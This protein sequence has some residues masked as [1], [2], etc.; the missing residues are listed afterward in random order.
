[1]G[2]FLRMNVGDSEKDKLQPV[3]DFS[4]SS[5]ERHFLLKVR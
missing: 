1:M 2:V 3:T 4:L 5:L